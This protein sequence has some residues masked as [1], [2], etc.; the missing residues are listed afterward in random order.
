M[1]TT[2]NGTKTKVNINVNSNLNNICESNE[3]S[4][5]VASQKSTKLNNVKSKATLSTNLPPKVSSK[6]VISNRR[7]RNRVTNHVLQENAVHKTVQSSN[8]DQKD[9]KMLKQN[10]EQMLL[11]EKED[12]QLATLLQGYENT[13]HLES[14]NR[15]IRY[16]L[17]SR[18]KMSSITNVSDCN[19]NGIHNNHDNTHSLISN[20]S[21]AQLTESEA[22]TQNTMRKRKTTNVVCDSNAIITRKTRRKY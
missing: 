9:N 15:S 3:Q 14:N 2:S 19:R 22:V 17:R 6:P 10:R 7:S 16:S 12:F 18:G 5:V 21:N 13:S 1:T 8:T 11:Q 20:D 4:T